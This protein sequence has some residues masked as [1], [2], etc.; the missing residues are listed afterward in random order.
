MNKMISSPPYTF[1]STHLEMELLGSINSVA[2]YPVSETR[3]QLISKKPEWL[4][5]L[6][7]CLN[8]KQL[9]INQPE[10]FLDNFLLDAKKFWRSGSKGNLLSGKWVQTD[11]QGIEHPFA[12][13][14]TFLMAQPILLVQHITESYLEIGRIL[15]FARE[16]AIRREK[17]ERLVYKDFLT[18][19]YNRRGFLLH[20]EESLL[21]A[22]NKQRPVTIACID[23]DG[24]KSVNDKYG[25]K[26]GDQLIINAANLFKKVFRKVDVLGRVG[27]DEFLALI[28]NMNSPQINNLNER[29]MQTFEAWNIKQEQDL[30]ISYSIGLACDNAKL[31]TLEQL[32]SQ[33][34]ENMYKQKRYKY[35]NKII[36]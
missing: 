13:I 17:I 8:E 33:A 15:Q 16:G 26:A 21:A 24:L 5:I 23:L 35:H 2:M 3:Y 10:G 20:A 11:A 19:L 22:R 34:D 28:V 25:H 4:D 9:V 12:A 36:S 6:G 1:P 14:A 32:I 29:L 31:Q 30:Q 7:C 27:G 18:G